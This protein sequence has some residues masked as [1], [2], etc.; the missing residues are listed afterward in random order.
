MLGVY[1]SDELVTH[2][3]LGND[4][5]WRLSVVAEF[6]PEVLDMYPEQVSGVNVGVSPDL[7]EKTLVREYASFIP[8]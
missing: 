2:A 1:W 5:A 3:M 6:L 8:D 4:D 7:G